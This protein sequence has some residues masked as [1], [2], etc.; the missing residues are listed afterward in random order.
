MSTRCPLH[1]QTNW[2]AE[3]ISLL[4][5][6]TVQRQQTRLHKVRVRVCVYQLTMGLVCTITTE[7]KKKWKES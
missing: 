4:S 2:K 6:A 1:T 5:S 3:I 7:E